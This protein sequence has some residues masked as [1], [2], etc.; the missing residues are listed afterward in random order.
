MELTGGSFTAPLYTSAFGND[1]QQQ[2][3]SRSLLVMSSCSS[4]LLHEPKNYNQPL[5]AS[6]ALLVTTKRLPKAPIRRLIYFSNSFFPK[7]YPHCYKISHYFGLVMH[8]Q[9]DL[10]IQ[11]I[12]PVQIPTRPPE[13]GFL[14]QKF[15]HCC[16]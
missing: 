5:S 16:K 8:K 14:L 13:V 1:H 4:Q 7:V 9:A 11:K 3:A 2:F 15:S 12:C 10:W 6:L